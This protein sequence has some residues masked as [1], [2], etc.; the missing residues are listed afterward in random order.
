LAQINAAKE[1]AQ[2]EENKMKARVKG[3]PAM[4]GSKNIIWDNIANTN[5]NN[6]SYFT[7]VEYELDLIS[8]VFKDIKGKTNE[9]ENKHDLEVDII[10]F[11]NNKTKEELK[12]LQVNDRINIVTDV[13]RVITKR[14]LLQNE[15]TKFHELMREI[16]TF[17]KIFSDVIKHGFPSFWNENRDLYPKKNYHKLLEYR[18]NRDNKFKNIDGTL[19]GQDVVELFAGDFELLHNM[20]MIFGKLPSPVYDKYTNLDEEVRNL[21]DHK[22]MMGKE[23]KILCQFAKLPLGRQGES[24]GTH[25][26]P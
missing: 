10:N 16:S 22:Y 18:R 3:K 7:L 23:C 21:N 13:K 12:D 19:K 2:K 14:I 9:L 24:S 5:F 1:Q 17:M 6:W 15:E 4:K 11:L 25:P 20:K 26:S 8:V